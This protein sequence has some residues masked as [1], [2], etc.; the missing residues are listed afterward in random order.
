MEVVVL[1]EIRN[2]RIQYVIKLQYSIQRIPLRMIRILQ[3]LIGRLRA[4]NLN[5]GVLGGIVVQNV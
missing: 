2:S 5:V 3:G 4:D 1:N